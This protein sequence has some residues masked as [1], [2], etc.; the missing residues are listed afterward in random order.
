MRSINHRA[1]VSIATLPDQHWTMSTRRIFYQ[2]TVCS[3]TLQSPSPQSRN[4]LDSQVAPGNLTALNLT[5][6]CRGTQ[7]CQK[8]EVWPQDNPGV[9]FRQPLICYPCRHSH[10]QP[11]DLY[12]V[13]TVTG[14]EPGLITLIAMS[15]FARS[16][17][18]VLFCRRLRTPTYPVFYHQSHKKDAD[19]S[20]TATTV[21]LTHY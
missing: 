8:R 3:M 1:V 11:Q 2:N 7:W 4:P 9:A 15:C 20:E 19:Y 5:V 21:H 18:L 10:L 6:L 17:S 14:Q 12:T 13:Y 16:P